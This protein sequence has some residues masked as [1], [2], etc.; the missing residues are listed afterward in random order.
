MTWLDLGVDWFEEEPNPPN[1]SALVIQRDAEQIW[2]ER[3]L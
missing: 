3:Y 2:R 1:A